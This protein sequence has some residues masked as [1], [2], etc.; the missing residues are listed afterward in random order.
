MRKA[1]HI[2]IISFIC[3]IYLFCSCTVMLISQEY[4]D[5]EFY[6]YEEPDYDFDEGF[7]EDV[8]YYEDIY[9]R[10][11]V[12]FSEYNLYER[13]IIFGRSVYSP[14]LESNQ[15]RYFYSNNL[16]YILD[17]NTGR[18]RRANRS[19]GV[20]LIF[21]T[22]NTPFYQNVGFNRPF[23][24]NY[25]GAA[26]RFNINFNIGPFFSFGFGNNR[27]NRRNN[28][29]WAPWR[30]NYGRYRSFGRFNRFN[31]F[32]RYG[33]YD[34]YPFGW[35]WRSQR[36]RPRQI[37]VTPERQREN[38]YASSNPRV[39]RDNNYRENGL[40][41]G[42]S[43]RPRNR[44]LNNQRVESRSTVGNNW[45]DTKKSDR[46]N[47]VPERKHSTS[48]TLRDSRNRSERSTSDSNTIR[49]S[50]ER[51]WKKE[52]RKAPRRHESNF[53]NSPKLKREKV[54]Q[55]GYSTE[56][57]NSKQQSYIKG[58]SRPQVRAQKKDYNR[59]HK[60]SSQQNQKQRSTKKTSKSNQKIR[61]N[62]NS[63]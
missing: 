25:L 45:N 57:R 46:Y 38:R 32:N 50:A 26:S 8:D 22:F 60:R 48:N 37:N 39:R 52:L 43:S 2:K 19:V 63:N 9:N 62:N 5:D 33:R 28:W 55:R 23:Y 1:K 29:G 14:F 36:D 11:I 58:K 10:D 59:S 16:L 21:N 4:Y 53:N 47:L 6:T 15:S 54:K 61:S 20:S 41:T 49:R 44:R 34:G 42:E 13:P 40:T 7:Y 12:D 17:Y 51:K 18:Y 27:F 56:R 3:F 24:P 31:S 30:N 35:G